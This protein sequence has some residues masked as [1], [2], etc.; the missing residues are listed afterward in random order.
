[1]SYV[2]AGAVLVGMT[3]CSKY[4]KGG[5]ELHGE[6]QHVI[7]PGHLEAE[8]AGRMASHVQLL[9]GLTSSERCLPVIL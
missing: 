2:L 7:A 1:M 3:Q 8:V 9:R 6:V 4:S 5:S